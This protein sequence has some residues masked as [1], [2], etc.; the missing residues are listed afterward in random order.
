M[1]AARPVGRARAPWHRRLAAALALGCAAAGAAPAEAD[2]PPPA[3][4]ALHAVARGP[5]APLADGWREHHARAAT[6][7]G[8][9][10]RHPL[11]ARWFA[12]RGLLADRAP[13]PAG[14]PFAVPHAEH[15]SA[16]RWVDPA[17]VRA[18]HLLFGGRG[19][20]WASRFGHVALRL[21]VCPRAAAS[22]RECDENLR[23]HLV[24]GFV[25]V[26]DGLEIDPL[27]GLAGGYTATLAAQDFM[28]AYREYAIHEF[29]EIRSLPL[30]LPPARVQQLVRELG[31]VHWQYADEYRFLTNNCATMLRNALR[32]LV[33]ELAADLAEPT[34]EADAVVRPD[35]LYERLRGAAT[36]AGARLADEAQAE[37]DGLYFSSTRPFFEQAADAL[38]LAM[39]EPWFVRFEQYAA[40]P[41]PQRLARWQADAPLQRQLGANARL[42]QAQMML[43]QWTVVQTARAL[44]TQA[45]LYFDD[46]RL[47]ARLQDAEAVPDAGLR[48]LIAD[49]LLQPMQRLRS[50]APRHAGVP[51][52]GDAP[53]LGGG[54]LV[55]AQ[56]QAALPRQA[57]ADT[58]ARLHPAG[59]ERW[60]Q[61]VRAAE[62]LAAGIDNVAWLR[63]R[64][65]PVQLS[66]S[67]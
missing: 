42:Q 3:F 34:D 67:R 66:A 2:T 23:E 33:P 60:Q 43:E 9:A 52:P 22:E 14:V 18:V 32:V 20:G 8:Y 7:P 62:E 17:Q 13:C 54:P 25:A 50:R 49:C 51:Q 63:A 5:A 26:V 19:D 53:A 30:A 21:V 45:A 28:Q 16:L 61:V 56:C 6:E 41:A 58:L 36:T 4:A 31:E 11:H 48:A 40:L 29:R 37:R 65:A 1:S 15:G 27:R 57:L 46:P 47:A 59:R 24:L 38:L 10:C 39:R 35:L 44:M 64:G 12:D 55:P